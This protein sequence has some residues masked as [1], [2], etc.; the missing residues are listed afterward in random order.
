MCRGGQ[1]PRGRRK[2]ICI[3]P[4]FPLYYMYIHIKRREKQEVQF[5]RQRVTGKSLKS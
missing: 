2:K 4:C 3:C 1:A 5:C